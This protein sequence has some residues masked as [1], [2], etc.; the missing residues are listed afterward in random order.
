MIGDVP[1]WSAF[2]LTSKI[3]RNPEFVSTDRQAVYLHGP[4]CFPTQAPDA[5]H[6]D[7]R[8][9]AWGASVR[10]SLQRNASGGSLSHAVCRIQGRN[11]FDG[12]TSP[13]IA[14]ATPRES[15]QLLGVP[16]P[17]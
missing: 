17:C 12:V 9:L 3:L 14:Q 11:A 4:A 13:S 15:T 16:R 5:D 2:D 6:V 8:A 7:Q 1:Q 10:L